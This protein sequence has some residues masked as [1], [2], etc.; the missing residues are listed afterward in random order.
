MIRPLTALTNEGVP[1]Y[2]IVLFPESRDVDGVRFQVSG[3]EEVLGD[4]QVNQGESITDGAIVAVFPRDNFDDQ[5]RENEVFVVF[6][7]PA[8]ASTLTSAN[9][10]LAPAGGAPLATDVDTPLTVLGIGDP[11]VVRITPSGPLAASQ[12]YEFTASESVTFGQDGN[13]EFNGAVPFSVFDT[14]GPARPESVALSAAPAGF[15]NRVNA[16][17]IETVQLAVTPPADAQ[18]GD[19]VVARIYGGDAETSPTF[20]LTFFEGTAT[21]DQPGVPVLVDFSGQLGSATSPSLDEGTLTFT[22]Q[23]QRGG[24]RSGFIHNEPDVRP[25][26]DVTPPKLVSVGAAGVDADIFTDTEALALYGVATEEL[27]AAALDDSVAPVAGL[28]GSSDGGR[29]LLSP[30]PLGRLAGPGSYSL[31]LTDASGNTADTTYTGQ[32]VQ[33]G[34]LTGALAGTLVVRVF[35]E[36]SLAPVAGATVLVDP[37]SPAVPAVGQLVA[38]TDQDGRATFSSALAAHTVTVVHPDYD[39]VSIVDT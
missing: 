37:S 39:L 20:D 24:D 2:E 32:I 21:V 30:V 13:L 11:R 38:T 36:V 7:K 12:R 28:F 27:S 29:F 31:T 6:D 18:P 1:V 35:D 8:N 22:A 9:L 15:E 25:A 34:V 10:A 16:T 14:V 4:F 3:S 23:M 26:L 33:R 17:N 5:P 19:T